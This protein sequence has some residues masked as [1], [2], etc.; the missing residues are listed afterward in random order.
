MLADDESIVVAIRKGG[1][2]NESA[3]GKL[4]R[5][6][7][8]K[9]IDQ[10]RYSLHKWGGNQE[11]TYDL[12]H[13]AFMVMIK[14]ITD[15][16]YK[17]GSLLHFWTG[18]AKGLLSNKLRRDW[19]LDLTDDEL[20]LDGIDPHSPEMIYLDEERKGHIHQLLSTLGSR[21]HKVL[22]LWMNNYSMQ[23]IADALSLSSDAMARKIKHQCMKKLNAM[24]SKDH[25]AKDRIQ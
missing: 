1:P 5:R 12:L 7:R 25:Q 21:C 17:Q 20:S 14:K 9:V 15:G 13:D 23:E 4:Y 22:M 8:D 24:L 19:K 3:R 6:Y 18:I 11:D 10:I 16:G 2:A